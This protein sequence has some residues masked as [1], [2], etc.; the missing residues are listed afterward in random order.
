M[1]ADAFLLISSV[2]QSGSAL[3]P[4]V[5]GLVSSKKGI[6]VVEPIVL[7]LLGGQAVFWYLVPKVQRR[8]D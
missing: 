7:A 4:L 6:W 5:V 1:H 3:F 8:A 2:G